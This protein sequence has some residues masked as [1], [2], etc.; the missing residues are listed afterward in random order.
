MTPS[1]IHIHTQSDAEA[2]FRVLVPRANMRDAAAC[3]TMLAA[4]LAT[5]EMPTAQSALAFEIA[6]RDG[7]VSFIVRGQPAR[8]AHARAQLA[9]AYPQ[10]QFETLGA[11]TDPLACLRAYTGHADPDHTVVMAEALQARELYLPLLTHR[12]RD[13][14][15]LQGVEGYG[16]AA[17]PLIPLV[18]ALS[19]LSAA[20]NEVAIFRVTLGPAEAGWAAHFRNTARLALERE[21]ADAIAAAHTPWLLLNP[22]IALSLL[23]GSAGVGFLALAHWLE[24]SGA[25]VIAGVL[26]VAFGLVFIPFWR[27]G[28]RRVDPELILRKCALTCAHARIDVFVRQTAHD[29]ETQRA[30]TRTDAFEQIRAAL[31]GFGH[32]GGNTLTLR[33]VSHAPGKPDHGNFDV[34]PLGPISR[35]LLPVPGLAYPARLAR[36]G[37]MLSI[38]ELATLWH[39]PLADADLQGVAHTTSRRL[40][41]RP[42]DV[43]DGVLL[44]QARAAGMTRDVRL[45]KRALSGNIGLVA[46]TRAG[47]SNLMAQLA[48]DA[49]TNDPEAVVIVIDPHRSLAEHVARL[50]PPDRAARTILWSLADRDRPFGLNPIERGRALSE[51]FADKLIHDL[52][53]AMERIWPNSW[54]DRMETY[55]QTPLLTLARAN[56]ALVSRRPLRMWRAHAMRMLAGDLSVASKHRLDQSA[57]A[58]IAEVF[59]CFDMLARPEAVTEQAHYDTVHALAERW[60][61]ATDAI[62]RNGLLDEARLLAIGRELQ[63]ALGLGAPVEQRSATNTPDADDAAERYVRRAPDDSGADWPLQ[64]SLLDVSAMLTN[65]KMRDGALRTL[66]QTRDAHLHAWWQRDVV[67]VNSVNPRLYTEMIGPVNRKIT[68][69]V[70]S[71]VARR[72]IGQPESTLD[73][74][75]ILSRGGALLVDLSAGEIGRDVAALIGSLLVNLIAYQVFS[76]QA[77]QGSNISSAPVRRVLLVIDEFQAVPG[78]NYALLLSELGKYGVQLVLG[79]QSLG[80]LNEVSR[81]TRLSWLANMSTLFAF[82]CSADDAETLAAE[83][84]ISAEDERTVTAA[85]IN[86]LPDYACF[87]RT[88]GA[89]GDPAVFRLETRKADDGDA[90]LA[91]TIRARSRERHGVD[92]ALVDRWLGMAFGFQQDGAV[93]AKPR[94]ERRWPRRA[95]R[96]PM[97]GNDNADDHK[98]GPDRAN[99]YVRPDDRAA[100]DALASEDDHVDAR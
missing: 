84:S 40:L 59:A 27:L 4:L 52:V 91:A 6:S 21:K 92:A 89:T 62:G 66:S 3:E 14:R 18:R 22:F 88:R 5:R 95:Q 58:A 97:P 93:S 30:S 47:K 13:P 60:R 55:L 72:I 25:P 75:M 2:A 45:S 70:L 10:C 78:A 86:G 100:F 53:R 41:P 98:V 63:A 15:A 34:R 23:L 56:D 12:T 81:E 99:A 76:R 73:L 39:L 16:G 74:N 1:D 43:Q 71:D 67:Q 65:A 90:A 24:L 57:R 48:A 46:R 50:T 36:G 17:D 61:A 80:V 29:S 94:A 49:I 64:Y 37:L 82:R 42:E 7:E 19:S 32:P 69:F 35:P 9:A 33:R 85:D 54:G 68:D 77:G 87:V 11:Q 83:L 44:G 96:V 8:V 79:T 31:S 51:P 26:F 28:G 20:S 38:D